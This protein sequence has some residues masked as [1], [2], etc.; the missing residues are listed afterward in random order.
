MRVTLWTVRVGD[1]YPEFCDITTAHMRSYADRIGADFRVIHQRKFPDRK[2]N[3]EKF[4]V[5]ICGNDSDYN[6]LMDADILLPP[7][8]PDLTEKV[9]VECVGAWTGYGAH[10]HFRNP[11]K[12]FLRDQRDLAIVTNMVVTTRLTHDA[13]EFPKESEKELERHC[14]NPWCTDEFVFSRNV[15]K[16]GLKHVNLLE[17]HEPQPIHFE[18][19][20]MKQQGRDPVKEARRI[21]ES[22][23]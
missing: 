14:W 23:R 16:Y 7:D 3:F 22:W 6:I 9:P 4:Q 5:G 21:I 1:Y 19:T 13:W 18:L 15:A 17:A 12:Y 11:D 10:Y 20:T 2:P 8:F